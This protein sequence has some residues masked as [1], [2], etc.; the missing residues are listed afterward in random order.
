MPVS[1]F[2]WNQLLAFYE[3]IKLLKVCSVIVSLKMVAAQK[4]PYSWTV[5]SINEKRR[6]RDG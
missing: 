2:N 1:E 6:C 5:I 4:L 3:S